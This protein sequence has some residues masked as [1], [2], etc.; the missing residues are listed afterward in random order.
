MI[1]TI[2]FYAQGRSKVT[3]TEVFGYK[4]GA[5]EPGETD[6]WT[7]TAMR[8]PVLPPSNL[9]G[10]RNINIDYEIIVRTIFFSLLTI[11]DLLPKNVLLYS[12]SFSSGLIQV[13]LALTSKW[14][15]LLLLEQSH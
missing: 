4:R 7:D 13:E 11:I 12:F 9:K 8:I 1:Q 3:T 14:S 2:T 10:C 15:F 6:T 5:I